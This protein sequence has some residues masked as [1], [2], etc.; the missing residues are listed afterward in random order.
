M[1]PSQRTT[2]LSCISFSLGCF[3]STPPVQC[4]KP[5]PILVQGLCLPNLIPWIYSSFPLYSPFPLYHFHIRYL[6]QVIP[7]W[8]SGFPYFLQLK[9]E[10]CNKELMIWVTVSSRS[11]FCWLYRTSLSLAAKNIINVIIW[12]YSRISGVVGNV[13]LL[14]PACSFD[15]TLLVFALL[16]FVFQGQTWLLF[17]VSL[18]FLLLHSNPLWL[19]FILKGVVDLHRICQL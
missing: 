16:Y 5:P 19:V 18:D 15:K 1:K 12:W 4:Y 2:L 9:P 6:I 13:C 17:W 7:E 14:W 10:F 11:C 8:T 3:Q